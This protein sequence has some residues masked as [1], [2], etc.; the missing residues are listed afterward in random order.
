MAM[1]DQQWIATESTEP[2]GWTGARH[3][4]TAK[5]GLL[6]YAGYLAIFYSVW[7]INDVDYP[8]IGG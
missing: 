6:V 5:L 4:P 3:P 1:S 2:P 7:A 8:T